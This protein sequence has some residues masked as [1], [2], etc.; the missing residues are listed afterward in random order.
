VCAPQ[1]ADI[2]DGIWQTYREEGVLVYGINNESLHILR[3]F[4]E[5]T[6]ITFPVIMG[7]PSGYTIYGGLSPFPR[8]Y[9]IDPEGIVQYAAT[10]YRPTEMSTIIERFLPTGVGED[11]DEDLSGS[12]VPRGFLLRQNYPN[13]FNPS[14]TIR[15]EL[16]P[17]KAPAEVELSIYSL[18]GKRVRALVSGVLE[19]GSRA[20][21][22]D[23]TDD[24]GNP[25]P[26]GVYIYRLKVGDERSVRKM[27]LTR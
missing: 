6:G 26:S 8:D 10:E 16:D 24:S 23:G 3:D 12:S 4:I 18:R 2:E 20:I 9:I 19:K 7:N 1:L 25:V 5:Q 22:W 14:T 27:L 11:N 13:P 21:H 15:F 17:A